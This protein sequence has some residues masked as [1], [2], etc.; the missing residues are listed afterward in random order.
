MGPQ[1][2]QAAAHRASTHAAAGAQRAV[3]GMHAGH[4][5][6]VFPGTSRRAP[7]RRR[8]SLPV[9]LVGLVFRLAFVVVWLAVAIAIVA[10]ALQQSNGG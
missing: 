9:R 7:R 2:G 8:R 4:R 10:F 1:M 6:N 3:A 5:R